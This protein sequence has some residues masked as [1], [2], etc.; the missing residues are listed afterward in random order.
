MNVGKNILA[1]RKSN[2]L[3][4]EQFGQLFHVTRQTVS[5][6]EKEKSF[7]D[8]QTLIRIS[9]RFDVSLDQL[10][11][12]DTHLVQ[13]IDRHRK[14]AKWGW[15]IIG[16]LIAA[17]LVMGFV[18]GGQGTP[19]EERNRSET[20]AAMYLNLPDQTPSR[21]IVRTFDKEEWEQFSQR[22]RA[23]IIDELSGRIEG[24]MPCLHVLSHEGN[25]GKQPKIRPVF[26]D[27]YQ[28]NRIPD[29]PAKVTITAYENCVKP[30]LENKEIRQ[31]KWQAKLQQDEDGFYFQIENPFGEYDQK[32]EK[33]EF[34]PC[35]LEVEY[36][37]EGN[38]YLSLSALNL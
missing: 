10:I 32:G 23:K 31:K 36:T 37:I 19:N 7:P 4:Q 25:P 16:I 1:I 22:K 18:T 9:N 27:L 24:D 13:T 6:W 3:S 26:Q 2:D 30:F 8:L 15:L 38:E 12:E 21:A 33:I 11:K 35:L 20:D 34:V 17:L 5:N 14:F 29:R 28:N